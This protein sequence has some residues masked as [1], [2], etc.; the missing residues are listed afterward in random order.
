MTHCDHPNQIQ[1]KQLR[2]WHWPDGPSILHSYS[3]YRHQKD[4][5]CLEEQW[6]RKCFPPFSLAKNAS[7]Y[8]AFACDIHPSAYPGF[9]MYH[10]YFTITA[11]ALLLLKFQHKE[12]INHQSQLSCNFFF[13]VS[14]SL[15]YVWLLGTRNKHFP[16]VKNRK[17]CLENNQL[18]SPWKKKCSNGGE[19]LD[20]FPN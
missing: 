4:C 7:V 9:P 13:P 14:K 5:A 10:T 17:Q 12:N 16:S 8:S 20:P 1:L 6:Q 2:E 15:Q 18:Y 3:S 11:T 19:R